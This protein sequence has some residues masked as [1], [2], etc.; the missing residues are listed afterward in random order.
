MSD[1]PEK[2]Q[3]LVNTQLKD[4]ETIQWI[5]QPLANYW[6]V[7]AMIAF[8]CG[9]CLT[10]GIIHEA[11]IVVRGFMFAFN[12]IYPFEAISMCLAGAFYLLLGLLLVFFSLK[13]RRTTKRTVYVITNRRAIII[14]RGRS[15]LN[16]TYYPK[17]FGNMWCEE[18]I[19]GVG[20][21]YFRGAEWSAPWYKAG[22]VNI[23]NVKE[24]ERLLLEL[25]RTKLA[26]GT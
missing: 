4:G 25:K 13:R 19:H 12:T 2:L 22:I 1:V 5:D 23:L 6:S 8:S 20:D 17:D 18:R 21:I 10:V 16:T 14:Q 11:I 26:E 15:L 9:I 7:G 24:V 3:E